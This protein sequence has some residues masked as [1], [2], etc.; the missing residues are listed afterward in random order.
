MIAI[1]IVNEN[2]IIEGE[3]ELFSI[4]EGHTNTEI[5]LIRF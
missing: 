5:F 4:F 2:L 1:I 3:G